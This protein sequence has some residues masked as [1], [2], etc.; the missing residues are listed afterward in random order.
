MQVGHLT[1]LVS[2]W[3]ARWQVFIV[4]GTLAFDQYKMELDTH[5][6]AAQCV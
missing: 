6:Y 1:D 5:A 4:Q 3:Q 2:G